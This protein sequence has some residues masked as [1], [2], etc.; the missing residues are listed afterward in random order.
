MTPLADAMFQLL[1]FFMLSASLT[2]YSLLTLRSASETLDDDPS[3]NSSPGP[4]GAAPS[5]SSDVAIWRVE[6]QG[7]IAGGQRVPIENIDA[8]A[9]AIAEIGAVHLLLIVLPDASVQDVSTVLARL[10]RANVQS[11]QVSR[12]EG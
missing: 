1:I 2:P 11:V 6:R 8:L 5:F 12:G 3:G 7:I 10:Q 9:E 4:G